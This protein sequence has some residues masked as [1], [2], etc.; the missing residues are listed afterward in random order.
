MI[1]DRLIAGL[2]TDV[3]RPGGESDPRFHRDWT[4]PAAVVPLAV[5]LPRSTEEVATALR[6]CNEAGIA[7]VPQG[8]MT[9]LVGG[10][11][12]ALDAVVINLSRLAPAPGIDTEA[13]TATVG[14]GTVL[15]DLQA[16]G[17]LGGSISAEHGI[18]TDKRAWLG[19]T[20]SEAEIETMRRIK[21]ALDPRGILNPGKLLLDTGVVARSLPKERIMS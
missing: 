2:G 11:M 7:V 20:R 3:V 15:Q 5:V 8:G 1:V 9:G 19:L 17:R 13:G 18:G 21:Q 16:A 12:P 14:A 10:A 6:I 4:A